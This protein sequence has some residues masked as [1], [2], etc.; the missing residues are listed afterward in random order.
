[1]LRPK[2]LDIYLIKKFLLLFV[3][4]FFICLFVLMM[5]FLWRIIDELIGKGLTLDIL[6]QF[7]WYLGLMLMPQAFPLAILLSSL[8]TFGNLGE[9]IELTAIKA[10][11]ISLMKAFR[12]LIAMSI[13][14]CCCSFY[15]QNV[16]GP[17]ANKKFYQLLLSMKQTSPELEIP[18]GSFYDGIPDRSI[19]VK[20]KDM[21]TGKLYDIM[22]YNRTGGFEDQAIILADSGMLQVTADKNHLQLSLW[23]GEWFE[24]VKS[25]EMMNSAGVPFRRETFI[26][27]KIILDY[28]GDFNLTDASNISG[29]ART[30]GLRQITHDIDSLDH[31][32]DSIGRAT[33]EDMSRSF[34]SIPKPIAGKTV[35]TAKKDTL[36]ESVDSIYAQLGKDR[37][38]QVAMNAMTNIQSETRDLEF[39]SLYTKD[40]ERYLRTHR[41]EAIAKFTLSFCCILFFF[42]GAPLGSII[43]KGGLGMPI[44]ISVLVFIFYYILENSGTKMAR[45]G[46]WNLYF[47]AFLSTGVLTPLAAWVTYKANNDSAVF[48]MDMYKEFFRRLLGLRIKRSVMG[49]EVIIMDP[50]YAKDAEIL[51][52]VCDEIREYSEAHS[53]KKAPNPIKVFFRYEPDHNIERISEILETTIEDLGNTRSKIILAELNR[54]PILSTKAHTRPFDRSWMNTMAGIIFPV[55]II[56]YIRMWRFRLR[57]NGDLNTITSAS[58]NIISEIRKMESSN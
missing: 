19:Y 42:I 18:E 36:A 47:G 58:M 23:M 14:I 8:I 57:L 20:H 3:G 16:V 15:F 5:Q 52:G 10:A 29:S 25:Q 12:S 11:G 55:G 32:Y 4:A 51:A 2:K 50:D 21:Q 35:A 7:F 31:E 44:V 26:D 46:S 48:N 43:R 24:N 9:S 49:K 56:L 45:A 28:S 6:A 39:R 40:G 1:M 54:Y 33:Y 38:K 34:Y 27:K 22:I 30:K 37:K 17:N 53:L 13:L 41:L